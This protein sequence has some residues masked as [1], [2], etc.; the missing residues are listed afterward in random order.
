VV[1]VIFNNDLLKFYTVEEKRSFVKELRRKKS[2]RVMVCFNAY[3][4]NIL[5]ENNYIRFQS[6]YPNSIAS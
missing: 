6:Y 5:G 2:E 3:P 1:L 4:S